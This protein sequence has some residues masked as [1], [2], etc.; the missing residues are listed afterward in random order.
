[1]ELGGLVALSVS[2]SSESSALAGLVPCRN[3]R[4]SSLGRAG[5]LGLPRQLAVVFPQEW[6]FVQD[7]YCH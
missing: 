2:E 3:T 6:D 4:M 1:M 7:F 5:I